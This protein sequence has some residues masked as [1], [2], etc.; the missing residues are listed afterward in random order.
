[1]WCLM[2]D[3]SSVPRVEAA[4]TGELLLAAVLAVCV[5]VIAA[6]LVRNLRGGR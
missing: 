6:M 1:M 4:P 2:L 5:C 3:I